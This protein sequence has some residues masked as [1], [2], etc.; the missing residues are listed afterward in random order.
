MQEFIRLRNAAG[1][2]VFQV[3]ADGSVYIKGT[4]EATQLIAGSAII[5]SAMIQNAAV[6]SLSSGTGGAATIPANGAATVATHAYTARGG[7]AIAFINV[8]GSTVPGQDRSTEDADMPRRCI[9]SV[10]VLHNGAAV[11]TEA[12][13]FN[14]QQ[15]WGIGTTCILPVFTGAGTL[16]VQVIAASYGSGSGAVTST[17]VAVFQ[18]VK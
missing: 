7:T 9:I 14:W 18:A 13:E 12:K 8:A 3:K 16:T 10:R 17:K 2:N 1:Q 15:V 6:T 4:I 5:G 11:W